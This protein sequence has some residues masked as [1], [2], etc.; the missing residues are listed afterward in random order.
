MKRGKVVKPVVS[1][2]RLWDAPT[3][4]LLEVELGAEYGGGHIIAFDVLGCGKEEPVL[5]AE[6]SVA[7]VWFHGK[8][9]PVD[10]LIIGS[11]E[12]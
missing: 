9:P 8:P 4:A 6:G 11:L 3:G 10:A 1:T 5:V 2:R 7:A 12:K